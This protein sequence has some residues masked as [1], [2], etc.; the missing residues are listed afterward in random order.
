MRWQAWFC[1]VDAGHGDN[2]KY[3]QRQRKDHERME[4]YSYRGGSNILIEAGFILFNVKFIHA[5]QYV[6]EAY[7]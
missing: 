3:K 1:K 2:G 4:L 7:P 5:V 6:I